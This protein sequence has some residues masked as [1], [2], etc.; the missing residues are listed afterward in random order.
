MQK[1]LLG[2]NVWAQF[3]SSAYGT[4]AQMHACVSMCVFYGVSSLLSWFKK[5]HSVWAVVCH[6]FFVCPYSALFT[7]SQLN[8]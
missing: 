3:C 1:H 5:L 4:C 7:Q 2:H 8:D 6:V